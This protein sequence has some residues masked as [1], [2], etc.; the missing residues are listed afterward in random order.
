MQPSFEIEKPETTPSGLSFSLLDFKFTISKDGKSSFEFYK[1]P[2]KKP[3]F[4]HH[5][6]AIPTK[7][8][9]NLIRNER[10]RMEDRCSSHIYL[11]YNTQ[12]HSTTS[13]ALMVIQRTL[14]SKQ[15]AHETPN[16]ILNLPT[17]NGH[18]LRSRTFLNDSITRSLAFL[19]K[20]C[21]GTHCP[22]ILLAQTSP[23]P[24][25]KECKCTRD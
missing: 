9:L 16:E 25:P 14:W 8:K 3:L 22:K 19:E 21:P 1:K 24:H 15:N 20:K 6:S 23:I 17:Q 10:K 7:S 4:V 18:T 2:A 13:F 5:Q 12:T 11:Q